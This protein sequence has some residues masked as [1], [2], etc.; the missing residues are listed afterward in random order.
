MSIRMQKVNRLLHKELSLILPAYL[1]DYKHLLVTVTD[2]HTTPDLDSAKVWVS[3]FN[4]KTEEEKQKCM[5]QL[6]KN[7]YDIQGELNGRVVLKRVPKITFLL[8]ESGEDISEISRIMEH[9]G[10]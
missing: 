1:G 4:T 9:G 10:G 3:V 6:Q 5:K 7:L 2:I 8:D